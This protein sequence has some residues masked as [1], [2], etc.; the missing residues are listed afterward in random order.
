MPEA[1]PPLAEII[2]LSQKNPDPFGLPDEI[3]ETNKSG[4]SKH[5]MQNACFEE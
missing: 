4:C 5:A 3:G 2:S 1:N